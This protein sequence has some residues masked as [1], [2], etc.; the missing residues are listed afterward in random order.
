MAAGGLDSPPV[1]NGPH[2]CRSGSLSA[3]N[4]PDPTPM[5]FYD[6]FVHW[7][8]SL[9]AQQVAHWL[10][11]GC[12]TLNEKGGFAGAKTMHGEGPK[13]RALAP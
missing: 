5:N 12:N 10:K 7:I 6:E 3:S 11:H 4:T 9:D 13:A 2:R 8:T 1:I